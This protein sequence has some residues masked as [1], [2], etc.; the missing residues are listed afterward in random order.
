MSLYQRRLAAALAPEPAPAPPRKGRDPLAP[1]G[2]QWFFARLCALECMHL[3]PAPPIVK[4]YLEGGNPELASSAPDEFAA[5]QPR[6][7]AAS[8]A[9]KF[10]VFAGLLPIGS[11]G[12][13]AAMS[14]MYAASG[15][16]A[17][18]SSWAIRALAM[19]ALDVAE[20]Q[21]GRPLSRAEREAILEAAR[22][23]LEGIFAERAREIIGGDHRL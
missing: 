2:A 10:C 17:G 11:A 22:L 3:W 19:E 15:N 6:M 4:E 12:S 9:S 16:I 8:E 21:L 18:A 20:S 13:R 14:A 1:T 23:K 5:G 7:T